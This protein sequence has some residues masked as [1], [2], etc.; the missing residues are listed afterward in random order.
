MNKKKAYVIGAN[1]STSLSPVIFEHWFKKYDVDAEYG[2]IEIKEE[3]FDG[4]IK[5]ILAKEDLV[6]LNVTIPF[7]ERI[8]PHL[9]SKNNGGVEEFFDP[10][11]EPHY[12][13]GE[14]ERPDHF[15]QLNR[16]IKLPIN[17]VTIYKNNIVGRNTDW[18]GF[19]KAYLQHCTTKIGEFTGGIRDVALVLGYGGAAKGIVYSLVKMGFEKVIIFNRTF[20]KIKN[21]NTVFERTKDVQECEV[22][23]EKIENLIKY[24]DYENFGE[25]QTKLIVNTTP[26]NPLNNHTNWNIDTGTVGFDIVYRPR[27]GTGFLEQFD[28]R[29]R[30]EGIQMLVYQAAPCFKMWFGIQPEVDEELFNVLYKKMDENK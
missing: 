26:T 11:L 3:N 7:K 19:E 21:I 16:E 30:I 25:G 6:G 1:V 5:Y 24:T 27:K 17:C 15:K 8:I 22:R 28:P 23:A 20:D 10:Y 18:I 14:K 13:G 2:F 9:T 4:E 29:C 12:K